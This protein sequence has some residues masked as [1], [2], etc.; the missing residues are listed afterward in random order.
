MSNFGNKG[1][2]KHK[3]QEDKK[4]RKHIKGFYETLGKIQGVA[5]SLKE[6]DI[7]I[8]EDNVNEHA[9]KIIGRDLDEM[10]KFLVLGKLSVNNENN[11]K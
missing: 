2:R 10:E 6:L 9:S 8:S 7:D 1:F 5:D 3:L 4:V 11:D